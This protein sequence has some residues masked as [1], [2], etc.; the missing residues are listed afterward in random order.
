MEKQQK[1]NKLREAMG[2]FAGFFRR[3]SENRG[4]DDWRKLGGYCLLAYLIDL[5]IAALFITEVKEYSAGTWLLLLTSLPVYALVYTAPGAVL[6][7][8]AAAVLTKCRRTRIAA[9]AAV[10]AISFGVTQLLLLADF[11]LLRNFGYHFNRFV[12]NLLTT[13]G[14]FRSMGLRENTIA[15]LALVIVAI[16]VFD[17]A[18]AY[19]VVVFRKGAAALRLYR[20]FGS[21]RKFAL[22]ALA[23]L[24]GLA[25]AVIFAWSFYVKDSAPVRASKCIPAYRRVTM[26]SF[27]KDLGLRE[28]SRDELLMRMPGRIGNYPR[29][30]IIRRADRKKYNVV[31]LVCESWR[32][33]MLTPEIMPRTW[34]FAGKYGVRF[35]RNFSGGNNTRMGVFSMFYGLYG[36][37]WH[38]FLAAR[39]GALLIDWLLEDGYDIRC[40][41]S[42]KFSYPE[43][44]H[45]V[46]ARLPGSSLVSDDEGDT[47]LRDARNTK[48]LLDFIAGDHRGAPFMAF[49]FFESPHYPYEFPPEN[50]VFKPYVGKVDYLELGPAHSEEIKNRYRNCCRTLDGFLGQVFDTL[51]K[52]G[53]L[54]NTVVILLGD[55][56]E[57]FFEHGK[58]GH[59]Q[60]FTGVQTRTPLVLH[61]P[62]RKPGVYDGM[63]SHLDVVAMVAPYLGVENPAADFSHGIDL[64]AP[65]APKRRYTVITQWSDSVF[66]AGEKYKMQLPIDE[67]DSIAASAYDADDRE[68]P[69]K[70][71]AYRENRNELIEVLRDLHRFE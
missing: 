47:Y 18:L 3:L 20:V 58:S 27:F 24:F 2:K 34:K 50:A 43:F 46:F 63:S 35:T 71:V 65:G 59:G 17:L 62:G 41:T 19:F 28:P 26:Y 68:L 16:L 12:W 4:F 5:G 54:D 10:G 6:T 8:L 23:A 9:A 44:D 21:W 48:R 11:G 55:H 31:W 15:L 64:L 69:D 22:I 29:R 42:A 14:G 66:F 37:Y 13:P 7:L 39:R 49:M 56:G 51:E 36:S 57:E 30:A 33:D 70:N 60:N 1:R 61:L 32:A 53:L 67:F 45:T 38:S 52:R 25:G 40:I